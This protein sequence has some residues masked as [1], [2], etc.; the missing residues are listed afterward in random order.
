MSEAS[1]TKFI[2]QCVAE[3]PC[4]GKDD[5]HCKMNESMTACLTCKRTLAEIKG[6]DSDTD[7]AQR[8]KICKELLDR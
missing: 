6:W 3:S 8:E 5:I 7:F 2:S 4:V 1:V